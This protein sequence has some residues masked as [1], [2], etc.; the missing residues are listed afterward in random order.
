MMPSTTR[1]WN[2]A[3][4]VTADGSGSEPVGFLSLLAQLVTII[5][6]D[7]VR[8]DAFFTGNWPAER[9]RTAFILPILRANS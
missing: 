3:G 2:L 8:A 5:R 7:A 9:R 4:G 6:L 1:F